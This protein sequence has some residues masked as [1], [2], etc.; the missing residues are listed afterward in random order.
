MKKILLIALAVITT[1]VLLWS[2]QKEVS[3]ETGATPS[4]PAGTPLTSSGWQFTGTTTA[5]ATNYSGC[6]DTAFY[7]TINSASFLRIEGS[8]A[9]GNFFYMLITAPSG[10]AAKGTYTASQGQAM[11]AAVIGNKN[12]AINTN[13]VNFKAEITDITDTSVTASF[14]GK[15][16]DPNT[17]TS[18]E[19]T[20]GK[21]KAYIARE[22]I[23]T[24]GGTTTPPPATTAVFTLT[25]GTAGA[26]GGAVVAGTYQ[27][28]SAVTSAEKV[29]LSVNVTTAG[30]Y[31]VQ[32]TATNGLTF[33]GSGTFTTTGAQTIV[34][35]ASGTPTNTGTTTIPVTAGTS[36]CSFTV[37]VTAGAPAAPNVW[38]FTEGTANYGGA[39]DSA[40]IITQSGAKFLV[41]EGAT[42]TGDTVLTLAAYLPTGVVQQTT[43]TSS[44]AFFYYD[45]Y[46]VNPSVTLYESDPQVTG[47]TVAITITKYDAA[48][49]TVEGTFTG[50]AK[51]KNGTLK[52]ITNGKFK[53][54]FN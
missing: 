29:T 50:K 26:C 5:G 9:G 47:S 53:A 23:C 31:S 35:Q 14:S 46:S 6:I 7:T 8:D 25:Q 16:L 2:C 10:K 20:A 54:K 30:A 45:D 18:L 13:D 15:L 37:T 34:L 24:G 28:N 40:S 39:T 42:V 21:L 48:G 3:V 44:S 36:N 32:T 1:S 38:S 33:S 4:N 49:K 41:I 17:N 43:Y 52:D 12:Y 11:M 51:D 22:N 27:T 19:I